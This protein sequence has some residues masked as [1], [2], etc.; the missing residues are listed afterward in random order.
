MT[1]EQI[2]VAQRYREHMA[3]VFGYD[4]SNVNF[5]Q[6]VIENMDRHF[7]P[8]SLDLV[9]SNCVIN[10]LADKEPV[11]AQVHSLLRLGGEFYFS[12]VYVD[13]R[14]PEAVRTDPVLH[15]E[16]LGGALYEEDF[17]RL[18]RRMG[19]PR[20]RSTR[21]VR[22]TRIPRPITTSAPSRA[23]PLLPCLFLKGWLHR[24]RNAS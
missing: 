9:T 2:A 17:L 3:G 23:R 7:A 22:S 8:D 24:L 1:P 6:D 10:L 16:C 19:Y 15:G 5:V 20:G 14:L 12:D 11:L 4:Q 13:R 21:L 18:A